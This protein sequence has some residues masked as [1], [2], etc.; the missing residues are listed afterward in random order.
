[1]LKYETEAIEEGAKAIAGVDEAGRGPLAGPV[2][3]AAV[4]LPADFRLDGLTD[5][6]Q[7]TAKQRDSFFDVIHGEARAVSWHAVS[8]ATIDEI[9]ILAASL[10]AMKQAVEALGVMADYILV[11]G[12][13]TI[14][15]NGPQKVIVK[16]DSLSLSIAAASVI[17]KVVRDRMMVE[18]ATQYPEYG[19]EK[20]KGYGA[21][22]HR[23]AI[24]KYGPSPIHRKT[25]KGV[26]EHLAP[27]EREKIKNGQMEL[28]V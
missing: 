12:N 27:F 18:Y 16:G 15:W 3:A 14:D 11:D 20:H 5:S 24:A 19:F 6:K 25:F 1:M 4:I 7:L 8:A 9:N 21:K 17:A 13:K 22:A 2:I 10:L 26:V 28:E 23:L